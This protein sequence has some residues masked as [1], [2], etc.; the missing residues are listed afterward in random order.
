MR[1]VTLYGMAL[2]SISLL[3]IVVFM[4]FRYNYFFIFFSKEILIPFF[5]AYIEANGYRKKKNSLL[6]IFYTL[7][8]SLLMLIAIFLLT[9]FV[10]TTDLEL[11]WLSEFSICE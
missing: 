1:F 7:F 8:G 6:F 2:L 9:Y 10:G 3:L 5:P 11:I 4:E